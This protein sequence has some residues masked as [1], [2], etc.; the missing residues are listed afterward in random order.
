MAVW[1]MKRDEEVR[2]VWSGLGEVW[3]GVK[4]SGARGGGEKEGR[5]DI[6]VDGVK[7]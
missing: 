4:V 2:G 6:S 7:H 1:R 5:M 3:D